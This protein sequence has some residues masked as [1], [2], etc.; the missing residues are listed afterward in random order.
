MA[1]TG[2]WVKPSTPFLPKSQV[3]EKLP[4]QYEYVSRVPLLIS[5]D[6]HIYASV[7]TPNVC[8]HRSPVRLLLRTSYQQDMTAKSPE[9]RP[10]AAEPTSD[11]TSN[12]GTFFGTTT[13]MEDFNDKVSAFTTVHQAATE[14]LLV[15][16]AR[17]CVCVCDRKTELLLFTLPFILCSRHVTASLK[18]A[19]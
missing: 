11:L 10:I 7:V 19:G 18:T 14:T 13:N 5:Y 12:S 2:E 1:Y 4:G 6:R 8:A 9:P 17:V 3:I 16:R 15:A